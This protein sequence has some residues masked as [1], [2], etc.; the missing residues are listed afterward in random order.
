MS[1]I[2]TREVSNQPMHSNSDSLHLVFNGEIYNFDEIK[3]QLNYNFKTN[4]DTEVILAA[5]EE[6]GLDWFIEQANGMF[7][8]ALY[9][10]LALW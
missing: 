5:V 3:S 4:S 10:S 8:M 6:R 9:N 1:I 2:D 7:A